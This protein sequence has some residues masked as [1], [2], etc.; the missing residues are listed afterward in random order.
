MTDIRG[1]KIEI[2]QTVTMIGNCHPRIIGHRH[3]VTGIR[4]DGDGW[5]VQ[6]KSTW[7]DETYYTEGLD[8][9]VEIAT[10]EQ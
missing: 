1:R 5:W 6:S 4:Q 10:S 7:R 8:P 3:E 9:I 2:G